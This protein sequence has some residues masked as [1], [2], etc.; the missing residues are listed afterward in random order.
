MH[1]IAEVIKGIPLKGNSPQGGGP[2]S[3][4]SPEEKLAVIEDSRNECEYA[5]SAVGVL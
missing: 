4:F 1:E 5:S 2:I 3:K